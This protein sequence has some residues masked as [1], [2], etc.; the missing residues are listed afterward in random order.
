MIARKPIH[1]L[2]EQERK[3]VVK[4]EELWLD[5][6]ARDK[7]Q[8]ASLVRIGDPVTLELGLQEL[9]NGLV[10]GPGMDNKTGLWV[11]MEALR[12]ADAAD[13]EVRI[14]LRFHGP[15]GDWI[16]GS[17]HQCLRD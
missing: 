8:A 3:Q 5:I 16:T 1:L 4:L 10:N 6:G 7:E 15:G 17:S 9:C 13:P 14:V 11:V 12:R 2:N